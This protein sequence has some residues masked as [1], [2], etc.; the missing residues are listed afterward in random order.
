LAITAATVAT[1]AAGLIWD[2]IKVRMGPVWD[3]RWAVTPT[4]AVVALV[5]YLH[6]IDRADAFDRNMRVTI[7]ARRLLEA[8]DSTQKWCADGAPN[9]PN[10]IPYAARLDSLKRFDLQVFGWAD[11]EQLKAFR[12]D[13]DRARY[14]TRYGK[15]K[16]DEY[17]P[18]LFRTPIL[19]RKASLKRLIENP[20]E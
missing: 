8:A 3:V 7:G 9:L 17:S 10:A 15:E 19:G 6:L 5:T 18:S 1:Y 13:Y 20:E 4:V 11:S 2:G 12:A 14:E 16:P